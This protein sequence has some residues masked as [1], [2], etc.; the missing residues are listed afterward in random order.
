MM[1][2]DEFSKVNYTTLE[3][4][5]VTMEMINFDMVMGNVIS[6]LDTKVQD[7]SNLVYVGISAGL[8]EGDKLLKHSNNVH[9]IRE[10]R[11]GDLVK[12]GESQE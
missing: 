3:A 10:C 11:D 6:F 12:E 9:L 7:K 1:N 8:F 5:Y 4:V 2:M